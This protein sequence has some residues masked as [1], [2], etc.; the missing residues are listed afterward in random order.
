MNKLESWEE[1]ASLYPILPEKYHWLFH[2]QEFVE[3][4][5]K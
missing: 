5:K 4:W 1:I 3:S 2:L